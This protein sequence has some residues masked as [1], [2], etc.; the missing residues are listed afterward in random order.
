MITRAVPVWLFIVLLICL[1][2]CNLEDSIEPPPIESLQQ[3]I[4]A[5]AAIGYC[6][7]IVVSA[8]KGLP[9]PANVTTRVSPG[10]LN[11][12]VDNLF[13]LPFNKGSG[14]ITIASLW[15]ETGGIM[16]VLF[17]GINPDDGDLKI[18]GFYA[19]PIA[20]DPSGEFITSV[21]ADQDIIIGNGSDTILDLSSIS[22]FFM[23][24][25]LD[26]LETT[27]PEDPFVAV[28][29]NVW[30][31]NTD[32]NGTS[33][34]VYD[35]DIKVSGGGQIAEVK[36]A[37]GGVMYHA[38]IDTK[39]NYLVCSKNPLSGYALTQ[40]FKAG[41]EPLIDLGNSLINF[42]SAC[43]G[44]AHIEISTGKYLGFSNRD[45]SLGLD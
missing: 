26:M 41:G 6:A 29:Q 44:K 43:D 33:D 34:N 19:V 1:E 32:Q 18:Y 3:G 20:E 27:E 36:D 7:S 22:S 30:I 21:Y 10:L 42:H 25:R 24:S 9:L 17:T 12:K 8:H 4:R 45:I 39:I 23:N 11:V 31:V 37:S 38:L 14:N 35:D 13:P 40:N 16:S 2:G 5:S 15:N 28:K